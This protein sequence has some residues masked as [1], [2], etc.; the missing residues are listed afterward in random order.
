ME[1]GAELEDIRAAD[2]SLVGTRV[3]GD[4][5]GAEAFAV[6]SHFQYVGHISPSSITQGCDF[7]DVHT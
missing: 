5:V 2:M 1:F 4:A 6:E 7:V 3:D